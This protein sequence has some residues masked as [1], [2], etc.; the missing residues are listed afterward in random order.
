MDAIV[1]AKTSVFDLVYHCLTFPELDDVFL[2]T[3]ATFRNQVHKN[4]HK[5]RSPLLHLKI[6]LISSFPLDYMHLVFLG[7]FKRLLTI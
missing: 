3:D 7:V 4:H 1:A 5:G 6:N 2:R